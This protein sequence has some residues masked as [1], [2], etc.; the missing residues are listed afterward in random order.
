MAEY[1][2]WNRD[3]SKLVPLDSDLEFEADMAGMRAIGNAI[4]NPDA[5]RDAVADDISKDDEQ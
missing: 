5:I 4:F 2:Y 1:T 3:Y